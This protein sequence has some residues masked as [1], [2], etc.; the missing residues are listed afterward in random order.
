MPGDTV[1]AHFYR[2]SRIF[3]D[4]KFTCPCVDLSYN[5]MKYSNA[6]ARLYELNQTIFTSLYASIGSEYLGVS[7]V[8]DIPYVYNE[9][10]SYS[11]S[12]SD[13]SLAAQMSGSWSA[14]AATGMPT[15]ATAWPVAY[16][17]VDFWSPTPQK[18][19]VNVLGGPYAGPAKISINSQEGPVGMEKILIRCAFWTSIYNELRT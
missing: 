11:N 18:A 8:S 17:R 5:V 16:S 12:S 15:D 4:S 1:N 3:R 9:V 13:K 6:D 10:T 7:H 2:A 19:I 14:F